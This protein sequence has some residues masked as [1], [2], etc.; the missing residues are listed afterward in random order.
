MNRNWLV[1]LE[2]ASVTQDPGSGENV[3]TWATLAADV[4]AEKHDVSDGERV[5]AAEVSAT[6]TT[7]FQI[8]WADEYSDLNPTDRLVCDGRTYDIWAVKEIGY[9]EDLEITASARA[10]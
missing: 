3:E 8:S 2:R 4:F 5:A 7:R 9:R 1:T 10:E 6:I